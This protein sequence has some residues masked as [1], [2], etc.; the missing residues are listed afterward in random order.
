MDVFLQFGN[1]SFIESNALQIIELVLIGLKS[2]DAV[3][4]RRRGRVTWFL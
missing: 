1:N 2:A 4:L 3:I